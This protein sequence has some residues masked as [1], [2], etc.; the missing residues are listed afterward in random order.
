MTIQAGA[1]VDPTPRGSASEI[2]LYLAEPAPP[3]DMDVLQWWGAHEDRFPHVARMAAQYLS[4]ACPAS[5]TTVERFFSLAGR[6]LDKCTAHMKEE[7]L[8]DRLWAK[9]NRGRRVKM[10]LGAVSDG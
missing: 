3:D 10:E 4:L 1:E 9:L 2:E 5:S 8:E 6:I 7:T